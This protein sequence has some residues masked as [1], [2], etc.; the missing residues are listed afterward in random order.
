MYRKFSLD[1]LLT[2][3]MIYWTTGSIVSSMRF[4]KENLNTNIEKRIDSKYEAKCLFCP[5]WASCCKSDNF[6]KSVVRCPFNRDLSL[7]LGREYLFLRDWLLSHR[8]WCIAPSHGHKYDIET[9]TPTLWCLAV[10]TS[11]PLKNPSC[12]PTTSSSSLKKW[13]SSKLLNVLSDQY[14]FFFCPFYYDRHFTHSTYKSL[15][16]WSFLPQNASYCL[17]CNIK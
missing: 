14:P 11:L 7:I 3:V 4:Y 1:D 16:L 5:L 13:R 6:L 17:I 12:W 8:S 9:S 2:N 15:S 10:A